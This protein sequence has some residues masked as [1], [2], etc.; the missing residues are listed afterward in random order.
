MSLARGLH[1]DHGVYRNDP[2][3][4]YPGTEAMTEPIV[5]PFEAAST[6]TGPPRQ[7]AGFTAPSK[8][9][10]RFSSGAVKILKSWLSNHTKNPY[11]G[12]GDVETMQR[13]TGLS[14]QQIITWLANARRRQKF[15]PQRQ[16]MPQDGPEGTPPI[17]VPRRQPTPIPF[18][19]MNPMERW[20]NS[21][22][23]H[24]PATAVAIA[25]AVSDFSPASDDIEQQRTRISQPVLSLRSSSS[26]SS[27]VT[28]QGSSHSLSSAYSHTSRASINSLDRLKKAIKR[29]R[30]RIA[31][32]RQDGDSVNPLLQGYHT[33]QCTFCTETFKTKHNWRRHE[34]SMHLSLEQWEC[35]P[36]GPTLVNDKGEHVCVY[37]GHVNPDQQHLAE[38]NY[39]TCQER[40]LEDR[41]FFRKD[42]LQQHLK[43]VHSAQFR[44]FPM[45]QWKYENEEIRSR[46]GFCGLVL[47][48]WT[49]R[50]DH[51]AEHFKEGKTMVDWRG[52][53]GFDRHVLDMVE[54]SVAPC[55]F[56]DLIHYE[57]H[58]PWPFTTHQGLPGTPTSAFELIKVELEYFSTNHV[59]KNHSAPSNDDLQYETCCIIFGSEM[60]APGSSP[61]PSSWLR[62]LFMSP[63]DIV[64]R[65]RVRPMKSAAK[66]RITELKIAGKEA[67]FANCMLEEQLHKYVDIPRLLGLEVGDDEL[68]HEACN[69]VTR[70]DASLPNP[71][72][73]FVNFLVSL[74]HRST[75]WLVPFR[76]RA[77][78]P[79][80]EEFEEAEAER[81]WATPDLSMNGIVL[82]QS[83]EEP[84]GVAEDQ[85]LDH[86]TDFLYLND[87]NCY[88][89]LAREL[90]RFVATTTSPRNPNSHVPTDGEL[91]YQ[92]R[93]IMFGG[94][95]PWNQTP[96]DNE[97][98]L[99]EFKK[100]V[101]LLPKE[102]G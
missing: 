1:S 98:W 43:L 31:P 91:Q 89:R 82:Q 48:S 65:A 86:G 78:L 100:D 13:Q 102:S 75:R 16:P 27:A 50:V 37:C 68:Q 47:T 72:D 5:D 66:S 36:S 87:S 39:G 51:V 61:S 24:E 26:A 80:V 56:T 11:P 35:S 85:E 14:R 64:D 40:S 33:F 21:P 62:D 95:D 42:H 45:E 97:E 88:R 93:W 8:I 15:Q 73:M 41:T 23:E 53:W 4:P 6:M 81:T 94:D 25:K 7:T 74:I 69:I 92:A 60:L 58:S 30:R 19:D 46:C 3:G 2:D 18:G 17:D 77:K 32:V 57:R 63:K 96:L 79:V 34:K 71:S 55:K 28:S 99:R 20:Q 70:M 29:R 84:P 49:D 90:S 54:N 83:I 59:N 101:G 22:P 12:V 38:H 44:K 52:E 9:G 67:I 76:K 10:K